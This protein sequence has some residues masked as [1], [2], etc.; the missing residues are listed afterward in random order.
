MGRLDIAGHAPPLTEGDVR[1]AIHASND[2][3]ALGRMRRAG[4]KWPWQVE[5]DG[6]SIRGR[7]GPAFSA[8]RG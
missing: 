2:L 7:R 8:K 4:G 6:R 3:D 5:T 1:R